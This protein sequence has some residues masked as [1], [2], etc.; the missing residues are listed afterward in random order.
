MGKSGKLSD[1]A[2]SQLAKEMIEGEEC[3]MTCHMI[4]AE[5]SLGRSTVIDLTTS[6]PNKFRQIDHRTIN[7]IIINNKKYVLKKGGKK[8]EE[9]PY[10]KDAPKWDFKQ[11]A[12]GNSFSG[13]SYFRAS[14]ESG[15]KI[16]TRCLG[17]DIT[18]S[19][20]VLETQMHNA[21]VYSSEEKLSLT[22]V[23]QLLESAN[24]ACFT[25]C[26]NTKVDD[27][28]IKEKLKSVK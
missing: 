3:T 20:D 27:K 12:V 14:G 24:S 13:A 19:R 16:Q 11:L 26:F 1:K 9:E 17:N 25:V 15:D 18:I 23:A 8:P 28:L 21:S 2:L 6:S 5:S 10:D 4:E 7:Y 22:K